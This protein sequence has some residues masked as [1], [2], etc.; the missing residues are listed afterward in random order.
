MASNDN[1]AGWTPG[2]TIPFGCLDFII[3]GEGTMDS[4]LEASVPPTSDSLDITKGLGSLWLGPPRGGN[5]WR[6][7]PRLAFAEVVGMLEEAT[8]VWSIPT[9]S[10]SQMVTKTG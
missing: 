7:V 4:A 9:L 2:M 5:G 8:K 3:N 6:R 1:D 10:F